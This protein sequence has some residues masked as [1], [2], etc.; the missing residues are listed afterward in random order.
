MNKVAVK[1]EYGGYLFGTLRRKGKNKSLVFLKETW[2]E[3]VVNNTDIYQSKEIEMSKEKIIDVLL[4]NVSFEEAEI[5]SYNQLLRLDEKVTLNINEL[6]K[7]FK[8]L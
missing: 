6:E 5:Y 3:V 7:A 2:E 8:Y 1:S 4:G